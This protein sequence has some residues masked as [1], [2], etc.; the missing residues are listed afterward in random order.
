MYIYR[1]VVCCMIHI[2]LNR[3]NVELGIFHSEVITY[4]SKHKP[5]FTVILR[6]IIY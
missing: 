2:S 6:I 4:N 1:F 3:D 5:K